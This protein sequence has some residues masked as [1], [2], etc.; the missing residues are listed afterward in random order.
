MYFRLRYTGLW[1]NTPSYAYN[2]LIQKQDGSGYF[3]A[4]GRTKL[5]LVDSTHVF[6]EKDCAIITEEQWRK[7]RATENHM[8][9]EVEISKIC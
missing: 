2:I 7:H 5:F 1:C 4:C 3:S 8:S 6:K 9:F